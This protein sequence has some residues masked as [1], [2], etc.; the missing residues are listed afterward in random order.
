MKRAMFLTAVLAATAALAGG[1]TADGTD[2]IKKIMDAVNKPTGIYFNLG[3][4]LK[5][6]S[7]NWKDV[8]VEAHDLAKLAADLPKATPPRGDKASWDKLSK[9]YADNAKALEKAV[10]NMDKDSALAIHAK[11]GGDACKAC[12][13]AHR[14]P[15]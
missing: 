8:K 7:P 4:D 10:N 11:M 3:Q 9:A 1:H 12:H 5:D 13:E 14:P 6:D 2:A 15:E